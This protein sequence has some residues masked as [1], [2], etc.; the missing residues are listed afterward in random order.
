MSHA[1]G[2]DIHGAS[3]HATVVQLCQDGFHL[4]GVHPVVGGAGVVLV[5]GADEGGILDASHVVG[6][7]AGVD[8]TWLLVRIQS[9]EG[10][11]LHEFLHEALVLLVGAVEEVDGAGIG[12]GCDLLH[13]LDDAGKLRNTPRDGDGGGQTVLGEV[14]HVVP[15]S[16][17]FSGRL[18]DVRDASE[19]SRRRPC[20]SLALETCFVTM[21]GKGS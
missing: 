5:D 11:G 18:D 9:H 14:G 20:L 15:S 2:N 4:L 19:R 21:M 13:P 8:G 10:A 7:G 17:H 16:Q 12:Q 3:H 1:E 6:I